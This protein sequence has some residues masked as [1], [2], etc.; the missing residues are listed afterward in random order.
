LIHTERD[1]ETLPHFPFKNR[2]VLLDVALE[3]G[4][5]L[6]KWKSQLTGRA[7]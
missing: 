5:K 2:S 4:G 1:V 3:M 6:E 7:H